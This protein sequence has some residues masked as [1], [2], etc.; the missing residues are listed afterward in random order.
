MVPAQAISYTISSIN[1]MHKK[2]IEDS[3]EIENADAYIN[4]WFP[5][6]FEILIIILSFI[7]SKNISFLVKNLAI[8][9]AFNNILSNAIFYAK[10]KIFIKH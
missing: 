7:K 2:L 9:R 6:L 4:I 5:R 3:L 1:S 8:K 10:K